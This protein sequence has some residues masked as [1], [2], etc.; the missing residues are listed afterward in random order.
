[1]VIQQDISSYTQNTIGSV[2]KLYPALA[3]LLG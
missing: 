2:W 1:M 3:T